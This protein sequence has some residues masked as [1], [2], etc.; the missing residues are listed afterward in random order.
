MCSKLPPVRLFG[1]LE[2]IQAWVFFPFFSSFFFFKKKISIHISDSSSPHSLIFLPVFLPGR[3]PLPC[4]AGSSKHT[5]KIWRGSMFLPNLV[6]QRGQ[7]GEE[8][9]DE[10]GS[11]RDIKGSRRSAPARPHNPALCLFKD[12]LAAVAFFSR[13]SSASVRIFF[14]RFCHES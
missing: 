2:C 13:N 14:L 8:K 11:R 12:R 5:W 10:R 1:G 7:K 6:T 4:S 9:E 3:K